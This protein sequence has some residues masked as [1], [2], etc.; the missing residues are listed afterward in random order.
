[1]EKGHTPDVGH[2]YLFAQ[3]W[4]PDHLVKSTKITK[5]LGNWIAFM[6]LKN[7]ATHHVAPVE[8]WRCPSCFIIESYAF[9]LDVS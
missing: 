1:M 9:D 6:N 2:T 7:K 4:Y 3:R 5:R 8:A